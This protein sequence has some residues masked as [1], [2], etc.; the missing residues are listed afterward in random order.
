M[1]TEHWQRRSFLR[2][3]AAGAA[4]VGVPAVALPA[5]DQP[6]KK[7]YTYKT[8]GRLEIKA[9]VYGADD[10]VRPVVM[11]IHGGALISGQR[12]G[13]DGALRDLLL[14]AGYVVVS[15]DYRL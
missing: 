15:I 3:L 10:K 6:A 8:A 14:K 9:D 7:T 1:M 12:G 11:W 5:D 13:I 2:F 4:A